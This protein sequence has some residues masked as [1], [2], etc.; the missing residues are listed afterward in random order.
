LQG[1]SF[2]NF[3]GAIQ[4]ID[5]DFDANGCMLLIIFKYL[6]FLKVVLF[7]ADKKSVIKNAMLF[8]RYDP[9]VLSH[10]RGGGLR[11]SLTWIAMLA[12]VC[13]LLIGPPKPDR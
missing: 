12:G 1:S 2:V 10:F 5:P 7:G 9:R 13:I 11:T 8:Q 4:Q 6:S 3:K